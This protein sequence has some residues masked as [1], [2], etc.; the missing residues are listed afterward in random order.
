[1]TYFTCSKITIQN[2]RLFSFCYAFN[3]GNVGISTTYLELKTT[4]FNQ[5]NKQFEGEYEVEKAELRSFMRGEEAIV[6]LFFKNSS[7]PYYQE[8]I[9]YFNGGAYGKFKVAKEGQ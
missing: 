3:K 8:H 6:I 5:F 9:E 7:I 1:M 4:E 2:Q